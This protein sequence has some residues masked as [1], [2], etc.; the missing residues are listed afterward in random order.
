MLHLNQWYKFKIKLM[1]KSIIHEHRF[2]KCLLSN[3]IPW[4]SPLMQRDWAEQVD[5]GRSAGEEEKRQLF[6]LVEVKEK[7]RRRLCSFPFPAVNCVLATPSLRD[8]LL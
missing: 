8:S 4:C 1:G 2:T 6:Q 5:W 7:Q 3:S